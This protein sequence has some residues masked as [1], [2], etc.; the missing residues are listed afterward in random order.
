M[1]DTLNPGESLRRDQSN[2][3]P[4]QSRISAN[5]RYLFILQSDG[6]LVLYKLAQTRKPLWDSKTF[7]KLTVNCIMQHDGNLVMHDPDGNPIFD[8]GT[9]DNPG[10]R[11]VVQDDGNVVIY[12]PGNVPIWATNTEQPP[13]PPAGDQ[14]IAQGD[15]MQ[16]GEVLR[17]NQFI[18]SANGQFVFI[19]QNDG[20]LVL[21]G[22]PGRTRPLWDS[23]FFRAL[24]CVCP[25][26]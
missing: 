20:N 6:N 1:A 8:T 3:H 15:D 14:P 11:L 26:S 9:F 7:D 25:Y 18:T 21:Y 22:D 16:P 23:T 10:S 5:G 2:F 4:D 17:P 13:V 19:F 12:K 24:N